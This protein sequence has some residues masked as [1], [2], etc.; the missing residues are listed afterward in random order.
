MGGGG[1]RAVYGARVLMREVRC[2]LEKQQVYGGQEKGGR[3]GGM[4]LS[5]SLITVRLIG[6]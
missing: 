4:W 1:Q 5:A 3:E 6:R 2:T